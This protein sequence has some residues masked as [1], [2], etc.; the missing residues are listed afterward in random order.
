MPLL[1]IDGVEVA[2]ISE[3]TA[4]E[5]LQLAGSGLGWER[6]ETFPTTVGRSSTEVRP[7]TTPREL[8]L[9]FKLSV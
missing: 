5:L 3:R 7:V 1:Q 8:A 2:E 6:D 9:L 4:A